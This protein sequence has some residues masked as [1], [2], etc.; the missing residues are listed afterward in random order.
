M[1]EIITRIYFGL[2]PFIWAFCT[3]NFATREKCRTGF[4]VTT[5]NLA[6]VGLGWCLNVAFG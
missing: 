4:V 5:M 6:A 2:L 3:F 1:F